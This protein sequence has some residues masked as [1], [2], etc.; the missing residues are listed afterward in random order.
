MAAQTNAVLSRLPKNCTQERR[1]RRLRQNIHGPPATPHDRTFPIPPE[2]QDLVLFDSGSEDLLR[3]IALGHN[4]LI[5]VLSG[6]LYFGDGTFSV[7]PEMFF[8]LYTIHAPVGNKYLPYVYFF[9][10][11]KLKQ[12]TAL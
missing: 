5:R 7:V 9:Y 2:Y 4:D 1:I 8:Q 11:I 10:R 12:P 6:E 3:I